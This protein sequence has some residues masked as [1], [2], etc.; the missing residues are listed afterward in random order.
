MIPKIESGNNTCTQ[1]FSAGKKF[2][3]IEQVS[4][5]EK[6]Q[7]TRSFTAVG[8]SVWTRFKTID[9]LG[10]INFQNVI[11]VLLRHVLKS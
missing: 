3:I 8:T 11:N 1:F 6:Q 10:I 9:V 5:S 4:N 7:V 2:K